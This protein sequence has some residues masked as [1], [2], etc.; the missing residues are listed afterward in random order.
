M[1]IEL[2]HY[3]RLERRLKKATGEKLDEREYARVTCFLSAFDRYEEHDEDQA[4][5]VFG[6]PGNT[7]TLVPKAMDQL[8]LNL[9]RLPGGIKG[10]ANAL[11]DLN[12]HSLLTARASY[13]RVTWFDGIRSMSEYGSDLYGALA[14]HYGFYWYFHPYE[15][16]DAAS[17][18]REKVQGNF[19]EVFHVGAFEL[20]SA[21]GAAFSARPR[22]TRHRSAAKSTKGRT[23]QGT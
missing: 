7:T 22:K 11:G 18:G 10:L 2:K 21:V 15:I 5:L 3:D 23:P 20:C 17:E 1:K 6:R 12:V 4:V 16:E 8:L 14:E 9:G 19:E 13:I